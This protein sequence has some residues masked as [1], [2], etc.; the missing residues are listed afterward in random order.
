MYCGWFIVYNPSVHMLR[1]LDDVS[2]SWARVLCRDGL[3]NVNLTNS[4]R[5]VVRLIGRDGFVE[6][7]E[8]YVSVILVRT[9]LEPNLRK[10]DML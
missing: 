3:A 5:Q 2:D 6:P 7:M 1:T 4:R 10:F 9:P 8:L